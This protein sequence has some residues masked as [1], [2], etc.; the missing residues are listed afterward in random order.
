MIKASDFFTIGAQVV[1]FTPDTGAFSPSAILASVLGRYPQRFNGEMQVLPLPDEVPPEVNRVELKS[2][3]SSWTV[4]AAPAR[5]GAAWSQTTA[6]QEIIAD[7]VAQ[8][9]D[10]V[11]NHFATNSH[12]SVNRLGMVLARAC[13][14]D[15]PAGTIIKRFC[16]SNAADPESPTAPFKHSVG[17]QINNLKKY[18]I[19]DALTIN[20]WVRCKSALLQDRKVVVFEQ[21]INTPEDFTSSFTPPKIAEFFAMA[22]SEADKILSLYF[23]N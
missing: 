11:G 5:F 7:V 3:D 23:P 12:I 17:F 1:A 15:D 14:D 19:D 21:D 16:S 4:T 2:K 9:A 10:V 22:V 13:H 6:T 8:C 18:S 20:S